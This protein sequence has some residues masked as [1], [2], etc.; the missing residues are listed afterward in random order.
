MISD[1][2]WGPALFKLNRP[3]GST[4]ASVASSNNVTD[5]AKRPMTAMIISEGS[6]FLPKSSGVLPIISPAMNIVIIAYKIIPIRPTPTPPKITSPIAMLKS[7]TRPVSGKKLSCIP[8]TPPS[9]VTVVDSAK[10]TVGTMPKRVSLPSRL[11]PPA[12]P[13]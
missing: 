6:S 5:G 9:E 10:R 3:A 13:R 2:P 11:M 4:T 8:S 1:S 12:T 7:S